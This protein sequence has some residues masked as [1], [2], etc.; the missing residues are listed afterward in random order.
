MRIE[1][2]LL[3]SPLKSSITRLILSYSRFSSISQAHGGVQPHDK[4][5]KRVDQPQLCHAA[6]EMTTSLGKGR[7]SKLSFGASQAIEVNVARMRAWS[8]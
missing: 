5:V 6:E 1:L 8:S 3:L 4:E 2:T 7:T